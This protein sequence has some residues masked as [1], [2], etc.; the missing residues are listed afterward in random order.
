MTWMSTIKTRRVLTMGI[1]LNGLNSG[2]ADTYSALLGGMGG[3][4]DAGGMGSLLSDYA[5]I[6]TAAK[7]R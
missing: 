2:M 3:G 5:G 7:A 6:K 4:D 1:N